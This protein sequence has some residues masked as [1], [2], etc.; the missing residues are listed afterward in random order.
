M[1]EKIVH[2]VGCPSPVFII[3]SIVSMIIL[4][5]YVQPIQK[6][7]PAG[8]WNNTA[9]HTAIGIFLIPYILEFVPEL[10]SSSWQLVIALVITLLDWISLLEDKTRYSEDKEFCLTGKIAKSMKFVPQWL[11]PSTWFKW[12]NSPDLS[13]C[14]G[15]A[16]VT[17]LLAHTAD[18]LSIILIAWTLLHNSLNRGMIVLIM[19]V[20]FALGAWYIARLTND[21]G[22]SDIRKY[23]QAM[24]NLDCEMN[25]E[26]EQAMKNL[27]CVRRSDSEDFNVEAI[28]QNINT[29][30]TGTNPRLWKDFERGILNLVITYLGIF[31]AWQVIFNDAGIETLQK[32]C[33]NWRF[34]W[35]HIPGIHAMKYF[36]KSVKGKGLFKPVSQLTLFAL[37][38]FANLLNTSYQFV[39]PSSEIKVLDVGNMRTE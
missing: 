26:S 18:T 6:G 25:S 4:T 30:K 15:N 23:E 14:R 10:S 20:Y 22:P 36:M 5:N 38:T 29:I 16:L 7:K 12:K 24:K 32:E 31:A 28:K 8:G 9:V 34:S 33:A 17:G 19:T 13:T 1:Y 11:K 37:P 35:N 27:D 2:S 3:A 39:A 21:D